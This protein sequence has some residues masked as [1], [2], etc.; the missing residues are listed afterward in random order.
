MSKNRNGFTLIEVMVAITV[1]SLVIIAAGSVFISISQSWQ[2][3]R[4]AIELLQNIRWTMELMTNE[5]RQGGNFTVVSGDRVQFEFSPGGPTRRVWYWRGD[6][7][8]YG[9]T[10]IIYRGAG[11]GLGAANGNRQELANFI[12]DN[13]SGNPIFALAGGRV[14]IELTASKESK[15]YSLRTQV[16]P[17]N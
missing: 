16:R 14:T 2:R 7:G 13:S 12:V 10:Q 3:Q 17:R 6:G 11:A 5:I 4:S 9:Q 1:F 8:T 15:S